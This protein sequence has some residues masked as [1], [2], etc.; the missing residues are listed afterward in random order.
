LHLGRESIK[1]DLMEIT[2][3]VQ[4]LLYKAIA[5]EFGQRAVKLE[6][7]T[8]E[9]PADQSHGDYSSN[10]ALKLKL[11]NLNPFDLAT[12]IVNAAR[13]LGLPEWLGKIDV[14]A[15]GFINLWLSEEYLSNQIKEV[16][17]QGGSYGQNDSLKNKKILL[18]HTSPNPQTTIML[19][20]LRN[21]FLGMAVSRI[22]EASGAKVTKDC[23][24]NDRGIHLC[25]A[26]LGYLIFA[27]KGE[28]SLKSLE[29]FREIESEQ[30]AKMIANLNWQELLGSWQVKPK[31]WLTGKDLKLKPDH[32]NLIW[33][34]LGSKAYELSEEIQNQAKEMLMTW[35]SKDKGVRILWQ[36]IMDWSKQGYKETYEK[37]GSQH[38]Y[39]WYES[40]HYQEGKDIV[41]E[42]LKKNVFRI[43][44]GAVV[45]DLERYGLTDNVVQKTDGTALYLTQ[46]LALTRLKTKKFPSDL[47][48][49]DIGQEQ[50]Y[51][52]KQLFAIC[53]QLGIGKKEKFY[54]LS[55]A[56]INFKGGGKMATRQGNVVMADEILAELEKKAGEIIKNSNQ[57]LRGKMVVAEQKNLTKVVA[58]AGIKYS[59]LKFSRETTMYFDAEESLSLDGDSGPYLQYVYARCQSVLAKSKLSNLPADALPEAAA[60]LQTGTHQA[61]Q[62]GYQIN[63]EEMTLMRAIYKYPEVILKAAETYSPN[64]IC[65]YLFDLA[66]KFNNLYNQHSILQSD[67]ETR[68]MRLGLTAATSQIIKNGLNLLGI[69]TPERM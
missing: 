8:I 50:D 32:A 31:D 61:L 44:E 5:A 63:P 45:T 51:Y 20:H 57:E 64:I 17:S 18:E 34:V 39:V 55:Y 6:Q 62:A 13:K 65:N 42:G 9:H 3:K 7:I 48:I 41:E 66:Q 10:I 59:L 53:E 36:Q 25:R 12:K 22:L 14:V 1:I 4:E 49:W 52:F 19:G 15:P 24:V 27:R 26:M 46:D 54:H 2:S 60:S 40:D 16:L 67:S 37:I 58:L 56:L 23:V 21:N 47:Y 38:D 68:K 11:D 29:N 35:E 43:S 33:Y 28:I 30:I 69:E